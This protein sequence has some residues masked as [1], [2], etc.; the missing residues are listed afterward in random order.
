MK[1]LQESTL[2]AYGEL[3]ARTPSSGWPGKLI[4]TTSSAAVQ[5]EFPPSAWAAASCIA[6]ACCLQI[7]A[8]AA[9]VR[10][11]LRDGAID[12]VVN[13]LDEALRVLKNEVR[14]RHPLAVALI[15]EPASAIAEAN[16]RG[17]LPDL[18]VAVPSMLSRQTCPSQPE[19]TTQLATWLNIHAWA[20]CEMTS[21][22]HLPE[23]AADDPRARWLRLL[24]RYQRSSAREP[25]WLWLAST[26]QN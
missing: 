21:E 3:L 26:G 18:A 11:Q 25:R 12:F 14:Q 9:A 7:D 10:A 1:S 16:A 22:S 13:T 15:G 2:Q 8:D 17:V 4:V 24:P 20:A 5:A 19:P 6:G 23:L